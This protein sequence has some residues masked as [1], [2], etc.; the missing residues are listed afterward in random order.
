MPATTL[1]ANPKPAHPAFVAT[2]GQPSKLNRP[3]M[4]YPLKSKHSGMHLFSPTIIHDRTLIT[5]WWLTQQSDVTSW[6]PQLVATISQPSKLKHHKMSYP[7]SIIHL[8]PSAQEHIPIL[9]PPH[10]TT[11]SPHF[12]ESPNSPYTTKIKLEPTRPN[13]RRPPRTRQQSPK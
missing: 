7:K 11:P 8:N 5:P 2:I 9:P 13:I 4:S 1:M 12:H 3:E 10:A 6:P